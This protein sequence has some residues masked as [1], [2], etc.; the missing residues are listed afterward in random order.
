MISAV[1]VRDPRSTNMARA[2]L[3]AQR[4]LKVRSVMRLKGSVYRERLLVA[5][6]KIVEQVDDA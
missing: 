3:L 2:A 4:V 1:C 6:R 5:P